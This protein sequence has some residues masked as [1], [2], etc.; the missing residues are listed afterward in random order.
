MKM[1]IENRQNKHKI[2]L[3]RIRNSLSQLLT[4]LNC[5]DKELSVVFVDDDEIREINR[6]YL[7]RDYTT[8]VISFSMLEG[9]YS[10]VNPSMLGDII[11]SLETAHRDALNDNIDFFDEIEFLLIHGLLHLLGYDHEN[12]SHHE[13]QKMKRLTNE[14]FF[15][16]RGYQIDF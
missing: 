2:L 3:H 4:N 15:K 5:E 6:I 12:T 10:D 7:K 11:I 8:N 16:L 14:L 9:E 13:A 1:Q